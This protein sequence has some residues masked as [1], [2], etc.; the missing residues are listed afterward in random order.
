L[1]V[2]GLYRFRVEEW[3]GFEPYVT[4]R[5][6]PISEE[7]EPGLE[8]E[9]LVSNVK[10]LF[11]K[12]LERSPY[13]PAELGTLVRELGDPRLLADITAGRLNLSK[14]EKQELLETLEVKERLRRVLSLINRELEILELGKKIQAQVK[15]E[16]D[17]AQKEYYLREHI[18][19]LQKELGEGEEKGQEIED[20]Q[21]RLEEAGLP[22]HAMKEA[23]RELTRLKRTPPPPPR[24]PGIPKYLGGVI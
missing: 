6:I 11:L 23:E 12:M 13:L 10:G 4:A 1:L 15:V 14:A 24:P 19:V 22:P 21:L 9:A 7:Y 3:V 2:Q 20:L 17:K 8:V 5:I 18:K 16:M